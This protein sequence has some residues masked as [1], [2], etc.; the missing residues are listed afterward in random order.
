MDDS[1]LKGL[2]CLCLNKNQD[3][4]TI[5]KMYCKPCAHLQQILI[6]WRLAPFK[7]SRKSQK[8]LDTQKFLF[9]ILMKSMRDLHRNVLFQT[10]KKKF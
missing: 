10:E 2:T 7:N 8:Q 3:T 9:W 6:S 1:I 4:T 5:L